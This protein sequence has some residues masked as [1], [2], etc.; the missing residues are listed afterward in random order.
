MKLITTT[1]M[2]IYSPVQGS[3]YWVKLHSCTALCAAV[4]ARLQDCPVLQQ[5]FTWHILITAQLLHSFRK[6]AA[7]SI[8]TGQE[9]RF[10][11]TGTALANEPT[12][13]F[14]TKFS[15]KGTKLQKTTSTLDK[16]VCPLA[17]LGL[18]IQSLMNG[19]SPGLGRL[20][21]VVPVWN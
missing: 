20:S 3:A 19:N 9:N 15:C 13:T 2:T 21:L 4:V 16:S 7:T 5:V 8:T 11:K 18:V 14:G 17:R 10:K 12:C 6:K 1:A